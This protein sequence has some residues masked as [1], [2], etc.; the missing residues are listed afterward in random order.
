MNNDR[1][2]ACSPGI[3]EDGK[4]VFKLQWPYVCAYAGVV[5][6]VLIFEYTIDGTIT[7]GHAHYTT[8]MVNYNNIRQSK[9]NAR[10]HVC[11]TINYDKHVPGI[12]IVKLIVS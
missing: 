7:C 9:T 1:P 2:P 5:Y 8:I 6:S 11:M 3:G 10:K 12:V 4:Q